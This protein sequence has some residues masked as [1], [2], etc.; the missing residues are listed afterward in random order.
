MAKDDTN[1]CPICGAYWECDCIPTMD[2]LIQEIAT[3]AGWKLGP[4]IELPVHPSLA[5][6]PRKGI[7][8]ESAILHE[9]NIRIEYADPPVEP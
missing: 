1:Y 2:G 4:T 8:I 6:L 7:V 9:S 3:S 5:G